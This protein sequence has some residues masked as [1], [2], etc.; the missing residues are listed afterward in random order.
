VPRERADGFAPGASLED[1]AQSCA[2]GAALVWR[3]ARCGGQGACIE[4]ASLAGEKV[5]IRD[6]KTGDTGPMLV[7]T[8]A[9]WDAFTAAIKTGELS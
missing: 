9:E 3:S 8:R 5:A 1:E 7:V 6:G 2:D 4:I